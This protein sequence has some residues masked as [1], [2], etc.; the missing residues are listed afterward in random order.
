MRRG[1]DERNRV[2]K[3][4]D[5]ERTAVRAGIDAARCGDFVPE[6]EMDKFYRLHLN[7][8]VIPGRA[9]REP[10]IHNP[11]REYGFRACASG[12]PCRPKAHPGMTANI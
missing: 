11:C 5:E 6:K 7:R 10:G 4:S 9:Q 12:R 1:T 3:L 2:Y 8:V